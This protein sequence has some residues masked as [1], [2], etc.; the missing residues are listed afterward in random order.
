VPAP[1]PP[2][3]A[4]R[5]TKKDGYSGVGAARRYDKSLRFVLEFEP[6]TE[7]GQSIFKAAIFI[8]IKSIYFIENFAFRGEG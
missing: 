3:P 2:A 4:A 7:T 5:S 8:N 6:Q 1:P